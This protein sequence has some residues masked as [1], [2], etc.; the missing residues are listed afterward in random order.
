MHFELE[1]ELADLHQKQAAL[2]FSSCYV[3]N[4]A[5]L[6]TLCSKLPNCVVFSDSLNHAS[7]IQGIKHSGAKKHL[8]R[9]NDMCHLEEL[10][11]QYDR[12]VPKLIAFE[13][14]YSMCGSI[15]NIKEICALAKK[16]GAYTFLD[17]VHA[18]GMYGERG[19]GI[20]EREDLLNQV[21]I[22]SGTLGKAY[23]VVGGYIAGSK[24]FIDVIRSYAPGFIFTTSL[25]PHIIAGCIASV[26][27]L[28]ENCKERQLHKMAVRKMKDKLN[29]RDFPV[30][31]NPSHIIPLMV[32]DAQKAKK[33][34]DELLNNHRIY[35]Q[36]IN[37]PTVPRGEERLRITPGPF[38]SEQMMDYLVDALEELWIKESVVFKSH[39]A[40]PAVDFVPLN[41]A[42]A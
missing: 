35:I 29:R 31:D 26:Q 8:F 16:Y 19:A 17:E 23:G 33:I 34:S 12:G 32:F 37:Y 39:S 11:Q 36:A 42:L 10:L 5:A 9:H 4:D 27:H 18:V 7:M 15:G 6:S 21:D 13:S 1:Q 41:V 38:H 14:V 30:L 25:P 2:V 40:C 20:A 24:H 22:I 28:K 3:A